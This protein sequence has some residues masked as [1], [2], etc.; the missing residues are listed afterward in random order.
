MRPALDVRHRL[1][2]F[3]VSAVIPASRAN[4]V[5]ETGQGLGRTVRRGAA[6]NSFYG[7]S[8]PRL[9]PYLLWERDLAE[10]RVSSPA[11]SPGSAGAGR[12][13]RY[14]WRLRPWPSS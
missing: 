6:R 5:Y 1:L 12:T 3:T 8:P 14:L 10:L 4:A 13:R 7:P 11:G 9:L 2:L